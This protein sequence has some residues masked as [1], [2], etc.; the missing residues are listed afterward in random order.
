MVATSQYNISIIQDDVGLLNLRPSWNSLLSDSAAN[1]VF[2]TWEWISS[3]WNIYGNGKDLA[4]VV[5]RRNGELV[6]IVPLYRVRRTVLKFLSLSEYRFL[7]DG[8]GD[9]DYLDL[10]VRRN[11]GTEVIEAIISWIVGTFPSNSIFY[12]NEIPESS[13]NLSIL[14]RCLEESGFYGEEGFVRCAYTE[15]PATWDDYIKTLRPRMRTKVRSLRRNFEKEA[16]QIDFFVL[17]DDRELEQRLQ[18][19]F[20]LHRMRWEKKFQTGVFVLPG[21]KDFYREISKEFLRKGWLRLYS[22]RIRER[23]IAHQF[24]FRYGDTV[25]LLQEGYDPTFEELEAGNLLR[26]MVLED[27]IREGV[28]VYDYLGGISFHKTAWGGDEKRS[29]RLKAGNR[30]I[31]LVRFVLQFPGITENI[32]QGVRK[33]VP[34]SLLEYRK[35]WLISRGRK[36]FAARSRDETDSPPEIHGR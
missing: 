20:D 5:A 7:G 14:R 2:L 35:K 28:K 31:L 13:P 10:I 6:A 25:F 12:F 11:D 4:V 30:K 21:K 17:K 34:E 33:L 27:C 22:I 24:C 18:S 19:L 29:V 26:S 32:K 3:W 1:T 9:S 8:S 15:L 36:A 16:G 23:Y